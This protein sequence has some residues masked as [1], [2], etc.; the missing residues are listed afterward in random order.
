MGQWGR[1][2]LF[3]SHSEWQAIPSGCHFDCNAFLPGLAQTSLVQNGTDK[4]FLKVKQQQQNA[5]TK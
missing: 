5:K 4:C 3:R 1:G 2:V